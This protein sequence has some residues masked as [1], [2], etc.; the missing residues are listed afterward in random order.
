MKEQR[1]AVET[2]R[3]TKTIFVSA[4]DQ[5]RIEQLKAEE[6]LAA[7]GKR[8]AQQP[9][10]PA[11]APARQ[12]PPA[13]RRPAAIPPSAFQ[14][15]VEE[16]EDEEDEEEEE[17]EGEEEED[18]D[19]EFEEDEDEEDEEVEVIK[20]PR[21][22]RK[23]E[24]EEEEDVE[25]EDEEAEIIGGDDTQEGPSSN[26]R[27]FGSRQQS[28]QI[29]T[30]FPTVWKASDMHAVDIAQ[31]LPPPKKTT[32]KEKG[33]TLDEVPLVVES[34]MAYGTVTPKVQQWFQDAVERGISGSGKGGRMQVVVSPNVRYDGVAATGFV[35]VAQKE[36][37]KENAF[38][39]PLDMYDALRLF[40]GMYALR[41]PRSRTAFYDAM[42]DEEHVLE[43]V[44]AVR[45]EADFQFTESFIGIYRQHD[46]HTQWEDVF[47]IIVQDGDHEASEECNSRLEEYRTLPLFEVFLRAD[48]EKAKAASITRR[49]EH[50]MSLLYQLEESGNSRVY[51]SDLEWSA[52]TFF[53]ENR[54]ILLPCETH[55]FHHGVDSSANGRRLTLYR[56]MAL[57]QAAEYFILTSAVG[58]GL[59]LLM[60]EQPGDTWSAM[61]N[62]ANYFPVDTSGLGEED[63]VPALLSSRIDGPAHNA[64]PAARRTLKWR[65]VE[66]EFGHREFMQSA[67]LEPF[68]IAISLF[69]GHELDNSLWNALK[70]PIGDLK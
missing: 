29:P 7:R 66:S 50:A 37:G 63:Q 31:S 41:V 36:E 11:R 43:M 44:K 12:P 27:N 23:V 49:R 14:K 10:P 17:E 55:I 53:N 40:Y 19:E 13:A 20:Y 38:R 8:T 34:A 42:G 56:G 69:A 46:V 2:E 1:R 51:E 47:W 45:D 70:T 64:F 18:E 60:G 52:E 6:K 39:V 25:S 68:A 5:W 48:F 59:T 61:P 54:S 35:V 22:S 30:I 3:K 4:K 21:E 62:T 65:Q 26:M 9:P 15:F 28:L 32:E 24:Q 33:M 67:N 57:V 16:Y 58:D